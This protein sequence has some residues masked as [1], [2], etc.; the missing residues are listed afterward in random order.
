MRLQQD[1][2]ID[3]VS[4][5]RGDYNRW[6][7][8][9]GGMENPTGYELAST[10]I[11]GSVAS[12]PR[13]VTGR[14]RTLEEAVQVIRSGDA[15]FVSLVRAQL[16]DPDLVRKTK[17]GVPEQ[18][19]PC[20]ACNQGCVGGLFR[21]QRMG[22]AVN[23]AVGNEIE[24]AEDRITPVSH[25]KKVF[26]VGGG[27]AGMEA[28][29][30]LALH[31]HRVILAEAQASLG[32]AIRLARKASNLR[33]VGD[34]SD[35]LEAEVYRL[36]VEVRLSSYINAEDV[37]AEGADIVIVA[38][39]SVPRMDGI[40]LAVPETRLPGHD[41]PHVI[42]SHQYFSAPDR[43]SKGERALVLDTVGHFEGLAVMENLLK[44]GYEVT[45]VT[46][47]ASMAPYV[48]T[49]LRDVPAL[50]RLYRLGNFELL[51]RHRLVE[52][53]KDDCAVRP[54]SAQIRLT[55][56]VPAT[57]VILVTPNTPLRAL[58]DELR[59]KPDFEVHL[60]GDALSPRDLQVAIS[61]GH[62]LAR[63]I[64]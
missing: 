22:C 41:L 55:R 44:Q 45:Y 14:F 46:H 5:S 24:M 32:G 56:K 37:C 61:E 53:N 6:D 11:I 36:G 58:Y 38:T 16:A 18:V 3:Y 26:I 29:R 54:L 40:Q 28:A 48:Q 42:S 12:V 64:R 39:G 7:T 13:I 27:P 31:G 57:L 23:P 19:R 25:P 4:L 63:G 51:L 62:R 47:S 35:W 20:I 59:D 34:I 21:F 2:L 43:T 1:Q 9:V 60:A 52:I 49:T 50:E 30:V 17:A 10:T 8:M 15:E 33:T